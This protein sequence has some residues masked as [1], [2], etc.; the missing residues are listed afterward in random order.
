MGTE[1]SVSDILEISEDHSE[2]DD[3]SQLDEWE[4]EELYYTKHF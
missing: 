2:V 1:P 4:D 3:F